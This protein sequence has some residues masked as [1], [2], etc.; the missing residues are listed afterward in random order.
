M[1]SKPIDQTTKGNVLPPRQSIW[2]F[3]RGRKDTFTT[4]DIS[5]ELK[6]NLL[7]SRTYLKSLVKAGFIEVVDLPRNAAQPVSYKFI[8]GPMTAPRVRK[9]G[10]RVT[11]GSGQNNMWRTM[12]MAGKFTL[13]DLARAASTDEVTV[14]IEAAKGYVGMLTRAGYLRKISDKPSLWTLPICKR[15]GP[16]APMIQRVKQV[17]DPNLNKVVWP[18]DQGEKS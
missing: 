6:I 17:F 1:S 16:L 2:K 18:V 5:N 14:S 12:K 10:S 15:T 9:D 13:P 3:I 11:Q 4:I 8:K 7:Q